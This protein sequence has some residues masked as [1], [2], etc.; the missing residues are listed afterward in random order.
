MLYAATHVDLCA[1]N[2]LFPA[3]LAPLA[4]RQLEVLARRQ[5]VGVLFGNEYLFAFRLAVHRLAHV[6]LAGAALDR[7]VKDREVPVDLHHR[8]RDEEPFAL[9][10]ESGRLPEVALFH[11]DAELAHRIPDFLGLERVPGL[12]PRPRTCIFRDRGDE[13]GALVV[14]AE[15]RAG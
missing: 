15:K 11:R 1:A 8:A 10:N 2:P 12:L 5:A 9:A 6:G 4:G 3:R 13:P 7:L 14:T